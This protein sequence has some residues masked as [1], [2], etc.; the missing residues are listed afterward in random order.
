MAKL[1]SPFT[2]SGTLDDLNF[3]DSKDGNFIRM[4][5]KTGITKAQFR[6]N[7]I[8]NPIRKHGKIFGFCSRKGNVFKQLVQ[9]FYKNVYALSLKGR[10]NKLML[11]IFREGTPQEDYDLQFH[12]GLCGMNA[13]SFLLGFEGNVHQQLKDVLAVPLSFE[14]DR[15]QL[16]LSTLTPLHDILWPEGA[17]Q[18][19][20][21]LALANWDNQSNSFETSFSTTILLTQTSQATAL[22]FELKPPK[23]HHLW[24]VFIHFRFSYMQYNQL[25]FLPKSSNSCTLIGVKREG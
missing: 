5:G 2:I 23:G 18:V 19:E 8:F 12:E 13:Q 6:D 21:Q 20:V 9:P 10:C 3:M 16:S 1:T 7:P 25:K 22:D 24:L 17:T 15:L 11:A 4:K 14:W